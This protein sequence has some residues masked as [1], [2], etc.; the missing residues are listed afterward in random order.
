MSIR[1]NLIRKVLEK[2]FEDWEEGT[3]EEQRARQEKAVR[4]SRK[5]PLGIEYQSLNI[6]G[7]PAAWFNPCDCKPGAILYLHGGAYCLGSIN[8]HRELVGRLAE[9]ANKKTLVIEYRLAPEHPYPAAL[10]DALTAY[11]WL[12]MQSI[13]PSRI[14]VAGDSAGGGLAL[15]LLAAVRD[16]GDPLPAGAVLLSPWT[17]LTLGGGSVFSNANIDPMLDRDHLLEKAGW[18]A[19][20]NSL[21]DP[22]IS[23]L[24]A[25]FT[26]FPPLLF[27]AGSDELLLDD[28]V[29]AAEAAQKAGVDVT[30]EIYEDMFHVFQMVPFLEET[31]RA[32]TSIKHFF[33]RVEG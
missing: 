10:E 29:R 13:E 19:G 9:T 8:T 6:N 32:M 15:A 14:I 11:Q 18:Y 17:D 1:I 33:E 2:Q 16:A 5:L 21:T 3:I 23:P 24:F 31:K 12:L 20:E 30:L 27:Q 7:I 22:L 28:S 26:G 25:D 4:F